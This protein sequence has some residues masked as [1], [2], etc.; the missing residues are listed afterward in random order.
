[1]GGNLVHLFTTVVAQ[2]KL[3]QRIPDEE[4][5]QKLGH[6]FKNVIY[7]NEHQTETTEQQKL[8]HATT[9]SAAPYDHDP[10]TWL[11]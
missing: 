11:Q 6:E 4:R 1:M 7:A 5:Q 10:L 3:T 2:V 8:G 9:G